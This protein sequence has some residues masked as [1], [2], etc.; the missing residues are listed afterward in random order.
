MLV[1][2]SSRTLR[3]DR[4][5]YGDPFLRG[6]GF[7]GGSRWRGGGLGVGLGYGWGQTWYLTDVSMLIRDG[8]TKQPLYETRAQ[9]EGLWADDAVRAALFEAAMKDFPRPAVNPR[10]I[11]V[12]IGPP[13]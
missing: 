3:Q 8:R 13:R 11:T 9:H 6:G 7:Y 12:Q 2:V 1:Q 10:R 4:G 5:Y